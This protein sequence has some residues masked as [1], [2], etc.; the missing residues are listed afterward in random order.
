VRTLGCAVVWLVACRPV[1]DGVDANKADPIGTQKPLVAK[2]AP[3]AEPELDA[4]P[5]GFDAGGRSSI[6]LLIVPCQ[7][8]GMM[9]HD[10][11][12]LP[13]TLK[14]HVTKALAKLDAPASQLRAY[15]TG[16]EVLL[17][18]PGWM[19][20]Q[21]RSVIGV[22]WMTVAPEPL[23]DNDW[24]HDVVIAG[25]KPMFDTSSRFDAAQIAAPL[26]PSLHPR[27]R[28]MIAGDGVPQGFAD[29]RFT[30][31]P[32]EVLSR[33]AA[34]V[35]EYED[36]PHTRGTGTR[37]G[38]GPGDGSIHGIVAN[39][40]TNDFYTLWWSAVR[41][42]AEFE[43]LGPVIVA[44]LEERLRCAPSDTMCLVGTPTR[45]NDAK[46]VDGG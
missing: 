24:T 31:W 15:S 22:R 17:G 10:P 37:W 21:H 44:D 16:D 28:T 20:T 23:D 18:P 3:T 6:D 5:A 35:V 7:G 27:I 12:K 11:P 33:H 13:R 4:L 1:S 9:T 14:V 25:E 46:E 43:I 29:V 40:V 32:D 34:N 38:I 2:V 42:S 41:L 39:R 45:P 26:F 8:D 30:P 36:P 19:C